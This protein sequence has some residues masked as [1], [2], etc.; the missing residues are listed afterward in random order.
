M[1]DMYA[2]YAFNFTGGSLLKWYRDNFAK[3]EAEQAK[4]QGI[5]VY[6]MLDN[7]ISPN[8]TDLIIVPHFAGSGTPDMN[9][10]ARG[11]IF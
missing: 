5:S 11:A 10:N 7:N 2:T 3:Y 9:A 4:Q 6:Q 8:P 1:P